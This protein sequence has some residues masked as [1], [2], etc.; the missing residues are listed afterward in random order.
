MSVTS[1]VVRQLEFEAF[2]LHPASTSPRQFSCRPAVVDFAPSGQRPSS[3]LSRD[4]TTALP[5][6]APIC[7]D[8]DTKRC[9]TCKRDKPLDQ[10]HLCARAP[11]GRQYSCIACRSEYDRTRRIL[12]ETQ[13][14]GESGMI[15][16]MLRLWKAPV[17][18]LRMEASSR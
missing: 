14:A 6:D 7:S 10:F 5:K 4:N 16:R 18:V 1:S 12:R 2:G 13:E 8:V 11:D 9:C 17:I 15:A 3:K